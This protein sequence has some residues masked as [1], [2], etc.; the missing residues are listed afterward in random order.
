MQNKEIRWERL[1][2]GMRK[3][4][5]RRGYAGADEELTVEKTPTTVFLDNWLTNAA[6]P[7]SSEGKKV[8]Q[9]FLSVPG[10][11]VALVLGRES[12]LGQQMSGD[13]AQVPDDA[14]PGEDFQRVVSDVDLPPE[15]ALACRGHKV[16]MVVVPA[17]AER[18]QREQPVILAGVTGFIAPRAE[19]VRERIDGEGIVPEKHRAQAE[20]PDKQRPSANKP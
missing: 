3:S 7:T 17:F 13:F 14:E 1:L 12:V 20:A 2:R 6:A 19:K 8:E 5:S 4:I 10:I 11:S 18:E 9:T 16:M 15:E